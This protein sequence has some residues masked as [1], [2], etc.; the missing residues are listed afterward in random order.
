[1]SLT[2]NAIACMFRMGASKENPSFTP[3]VQIVHLK[4][5]DNKSGGDERWRV[6]NFYGTD[7][8]GF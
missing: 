1:M 4:K 2:P 7:V 3:T 8:L 5:I 6:G